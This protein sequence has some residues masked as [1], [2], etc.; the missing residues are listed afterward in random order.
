MTRLFRGAATV[1][2]STLFAAICYYVGD[3]NATNRALK[4]VFPSPIPI[5]ETIRAKLPAQ[6]ASLQTQASATTE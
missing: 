4:L 1:I 3:L 6:Y 5:T 2:V